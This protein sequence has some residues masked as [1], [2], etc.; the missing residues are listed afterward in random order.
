MNLNDYT[1]LKFQQHREQE[2]ETVRKQ[3]ARIRD[4]K[5]QQEAQRGIIPYKFRK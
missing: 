2:I 4:A 1:A 5:E 3:Q